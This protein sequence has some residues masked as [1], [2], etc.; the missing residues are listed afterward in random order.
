MLGRVIELVSERVKGEERDFYY[1][2]TANIHVIFHFGSGAPSG[3]PPPIDPMGATQML[4]NNPMFS[5]AAQQYGEQL[6]TRGQAYVGQNVSRFLAVSHIKT[7]F[8]VDTNYVL[9][10]LAILLFPF[11]HRNWSSQYQQTEPLPPRQEINS[12]D[13]YIP[14]T[15]VGWFI[16]RRTYLKHDIHCTSTCTCNLPPLLLKARHLSTGFSRLE[17]PK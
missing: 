15:Y 6:A 1:L 5:A 17:V 8:A 16:N 3:P 11:T 7:Y 4:V 9:K 12:P 10:K 14:G 13:L 2:S